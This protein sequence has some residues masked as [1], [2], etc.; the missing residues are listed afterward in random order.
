METTGAE[1]AS[2]RPSSVAIDDAAE[3]TSSG[4]RPEM[5]VVAHNVAK[6]HN[7]GM[8]MRSCTAFDV[9]ALV[10]IGSRKFNA[11]GSQGA[12]AHVAF[13]HYETL[14]EARE[15]LTAKRGVT[16]VLGVEIVESAE[17]IESHPFTGNTAFVM[18]NE[19]CFNA[20]RFNARLTRARAV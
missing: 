3:P 19:V 2:D 5:Y 20:K 13:E 18:G 11:F 9:K 10:L 16:R 14:R 1:A 8:M 15:G 7:L 17:P 12:D 6:R 4:R